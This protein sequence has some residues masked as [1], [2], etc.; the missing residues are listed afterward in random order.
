MDL[1]QKVLVLGVGCHF[2]VACP[3]HFGYYVSTVGKDFIKM[4][5]VEEWVV[6]LGFN[7]E[8]LMNFST[9][10]CQ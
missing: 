6:I 5:M 8:N 9:P 7:K 3:P 2:I 4:N 10:S 1:G